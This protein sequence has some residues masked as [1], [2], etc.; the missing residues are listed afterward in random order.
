MLDR[1][2]LGDLVAVPVGDQGSGKIVANC[3]ICDDSY[4]F[5][6]KGVSFRAE[7]FDV[8]LRGW[9][10]K[11][12]G[13][14]RHYDFM[15]YEYGAVTDPGDTPASFFRLAANELPVWPKAPLPVVRAV[16]GEELVVH[17]V[18]PGGRAR[19]RAFV[20]IAQDYDDLFPGFGFPRGALLAPGKAMTASITKPR[21]AVMLGQGLA[22]AALALIA[23]AEPLAAQASLSAELA[24]LDP[25]S[26]RPVRADGGEK[27]RLRV[28][29]S[30]PATGAPPRGLYLRAWA[31]PVAE[32]NPSC[33]RRAEL[34]RDAAHADRVGRSERDPD[35][36]A[37]PRCLGQRDRPQAQPLQLEHDRGAC[38]GRD[39]RSGGG[40]PAH[41]AALDRQARGGGSRRPIWPGRGARRW[42]RASG[43]SGRL[44]W[45]RTGGSGPEPGRGR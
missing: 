39:A 29:L 20:A 15:A 5:G 14:E 12:T 30:E 41:D 27:L 35:G 9:Q 1:L 33:A 3:M 6:E 8:R 19:Q 10:G 7:P 13:I 28:R 44:P 45:R 31:R 38:A 11:P 4:D 32:D 23:G 24:L 43:C 2:D 42:P 17:V 16:A 25:L 21:E 26:E 40:R 34:S 22:V 36:D 37:Q 18:H